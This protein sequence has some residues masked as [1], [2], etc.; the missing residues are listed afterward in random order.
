[1]KTEQRNYDSEPPAPLA[2]Q[3]TEEAKARA[4]RRRTV[5]SIPARPGATR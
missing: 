1:M 5:R 3:P 2:K 4:T